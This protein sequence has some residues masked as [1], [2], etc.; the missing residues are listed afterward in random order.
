MRILAHNIRIFL[1]VLFILRPG[2]FSFSAA[3]ETDLAVSEHELKAAYLYNFILFTKWPGEI[4]KTSSGPA[5]HII[6]SVLGSNQI[7]KA[8][9]EVEG[10]IIES[11]NKK[12]VIKRFEDFPGDTDI[13]NCNLL[14]IDS[15]EVKN[16]DKIFYVIKK[17][18]VLTVSDIEGFL[19]AGGMIKLDQIGSKL[20][21]SIN[22]TAIEAAGLQIS[23]QLYNLAT[24]IIEKP[25]VRNR[26][27]KEK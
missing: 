9:T 1:V 11:K 10:K 21:W 20:R 24:K 13:C 22:R 8:L 3:S 2:T 19:E 5:S 15:S 27:V 25:V 12:L 18:P 16:L 7:S 4:D 17:R 26:L 6:I 14:F 23:S